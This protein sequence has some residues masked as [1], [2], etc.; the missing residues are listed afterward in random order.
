MSFKFNPFTGTLDDVGAITSTT[1]DITLTSFSIANNQVAAAD[2][3][4]LT[5][6]NASVR[7]AEILFSVAIDATADLFEAGKIILIQRGADW[8]MSQSSVGD[9]SGV[10]FSVT[11]AGQVQ[12]TST[13]NAGFVTGTVKFRAI[14]TTV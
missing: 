12:Y 13:N 4:G 2:V 9:V 6:A 5:F 1:G 14:V 3:T 11:T 7:A 8:Q 10:V